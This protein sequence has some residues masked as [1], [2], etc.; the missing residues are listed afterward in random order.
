MESLP[1]HRERERGDACLEPTERRDVG[2]ALAA[3]EE[4]LRYLECDLSFSIA[5]I[6]EEQV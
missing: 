4:E 6:M 3:L 1:I 2:F 5:I